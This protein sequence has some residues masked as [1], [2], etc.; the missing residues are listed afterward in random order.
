MAEGKSSGNFAVGYQGSSEVNLVNS[1]SAEAKSL[2]QLFAEFDAI[3]A[4]IVEYQKE[5]DQLGFETRAI[6]SELGEIVARL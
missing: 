1:E 5:T 6:L 4:R 2:D 3:D